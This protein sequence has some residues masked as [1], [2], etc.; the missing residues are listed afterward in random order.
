MTKFLGF[1]SSLKLAVILLVL[2]LLGLAVG[3][4]IESRVGVEAAGRLVYY[5]WWFLG[6]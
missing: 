3:T 4:I 6:L 1:L 2:L 5:S